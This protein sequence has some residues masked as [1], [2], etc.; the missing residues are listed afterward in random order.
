MGLGLALAFGIGCGAGM[1][2]SSFLVP[3]ARAGTNPVR[4]EYTCFAGSKGITERSNQSG[5][6]G[7]E[8]VA[9]AGYGYAVGSAWGGTS[10]MVWCFK[11]ALP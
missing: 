7:W 5:A 9:G 11:R 8:M 4:W 2:A 3:P 10:R 1:G 6:Q